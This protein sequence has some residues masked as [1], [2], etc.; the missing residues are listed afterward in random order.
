MEF[1]GLYLCHKGRYCS[2]TF[3]E[4]IL[5]VGLPENAIKLKCDPLT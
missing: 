1:F 4:A 3:N 5:K 2:E